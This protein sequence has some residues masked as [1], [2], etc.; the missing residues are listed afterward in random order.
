MA[1]FFLEKSMKFQYITDGDECPESIVFMGKI[2]F[3]LNG[4]SVEVTDEFMIKKLLGN[5][6]FKVIKEESKTLKLK[7]HR[8]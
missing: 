1:P 7:T 2:K 3:T 5:S 6:S 4:D 8:H